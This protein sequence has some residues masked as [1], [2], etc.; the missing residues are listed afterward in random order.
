MEV[1]TKYNVGVAEIRIVKLGNGEYQY[2]VNEDLINSYRGV[3]EGRIEEILHAVPDNDV[4]SLAIVK[5]ARE[6]LGD[7]YDPAVLAYLVRREM[8]YKKLQPVIDDPFVED[9]SIVG[10]GTVWVRHSYV[11]A[12]DPRADYMQSNIVIESM[13]ELLYYMN[14]LAEKSGKVLTKATPVLDFNLP[15]EDG[16]HRVHIALPEVAG[17]CGEL[18][19]RKKKPQS[20]LKIKDLVKWGM[21]VKPIAEFIRMVVERRGSLIIVGPPGSGKTTLLR[22]ILY[23]TIP[24]NWKVAIIED[25][26]EIDPPLGSS[27][28]RY[29]VPVSPWGGREVLDQMALAKAALRSSIS[30]FIVIGETRGVEARVLVQAMNMGLGGL[31]TFH[32]GSAEEAL[33]RLT[34]PP[35]SLTPSQVSMFWAIIT[36]NYVVDGGLKRAVVSIDEPVYS[37]DDDT[38]FL[39]NI[40][41]YGE[42][43]TVDDLLRRSRKFGRVKYAL[44]VAGRVA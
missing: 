33:V 17:E 29:V 3:V 26:P 12:R 6:I 18:V 2:V 23:D 40:Y 43:V 15:E 42:E 32:G 9:I 24:K 44:E 20:N 36:V 10:P 31:T 39:N 11:M 5:A 35:I 4:S 21:L 7:N 37:R 30:R 13:E 16:G 27:W 19:I 41:S 8:K 28:V 25:T 14:L 38:V 34:S 1:V 22:A